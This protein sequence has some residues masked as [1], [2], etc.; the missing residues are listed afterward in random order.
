MYFTWHN[1]KVLLNSTGVA[2]FDAKI[3]LDTNLNPLYLTQ[4]TH[5]Q[6]FNAGAGIGGQFSL[7]YFLT[8][9]DPLKTFM[10]Y[11]NDVISGYFGGLYFRSGYL[12]S[13][14]L[15]CSPNAPVIASADIAFFDQ[16]SGSF[17]KTYDRSTGTKILNFCDAS[18]IDTSNDG[19][20]GSLGKLSGINDIQ[21]SFQSN[22]NPLYLAGDQLPAA[23]NFGKKDLLAS[24]VVDCYSGDLPITGKP[25]GIK[26]NFNHP[27]L[28]GLSESFG[29]S[30]V[31]FKRDLESTV[32]DFVKA[33]LYIRQSFADPLPGITTV[34]N[35]S[36]APGASITINGTN[37]QNTLSV[38]IR[39][40]AASFTV[41]S[42]TQLTVTV[43]NDV[44][45]G[46]VVITT[47][48][49]IVR[50]G[51]FTPTYP[52][53]TVD[54]LQTISG[55]IS[56]LAF[57]SGSNFY[58]VTDVR[59][60]TTSPGLFTGSSGFSVLN[61]SLIAAPIPIDAAWGPVL[62]MATGRNVSGQ[63]TEKFVPI[64]TIYGFYPPSGLSGDSIII[65]GQGFSGVTGILIN[66]LPAISPFTATNTVV[67]N[68]GISFTVPTGN[69]RGLIKI[70]AQSGISTTSINSFGPFASIT[71][72]IPLSG[73]T[74][75]ALYILGHNLFPDIMYSLGNDSFAV[76]F[77]NNATGVFFRT[78]FVNPRFTGL[79]GL[80]PYGAKSGI[81]GIN[82]DSV[83]TYPS[84]TLFTLINEPP[85]IIGVSPKSGMYSGYID[86]TGTN[87]FDVSAV[88]LS[89]L[90]VITT[91]SNPTPL[92]NAAGDTVSFRVPVLTPK[93]TGDIYTVIVE[94]YMGANATGNA[95]FTILDSPIFSGFTG[96]ALLGTSG[97]LGDKILV[98]GKNI[99]PNSQIF[100]PYTGLSGESGQAF[101]DSGYFLSNN[102]QIVFY[103]PPSART[104]LSNIILYNG[105][106]YAS[107]ANFKLINRPTLSGNQYWNAISGEWGTGISISGSFLSNVTGV[108]IGTGI[109]ATFTIIT[110]TGITFTVPENS[111]T[112]YV[113]IYSLAGSSTSTGKL[114]IYTPLPTFS[115]FSPTRGYSGDQ[116]IFSGTRLNTVDTIYF[117]GGNTQVAFDYRYFTRVGSTGINL[118]IPGGITSGQ[119]TIRN[120][121][122]LV[123][124]SAFFEPFLLPS[125]S[126]FTPTF[127]AHT[128]SI[129]ITGSN[130]SGMYVWFISPNSGKYVSGLNQTRV[131]TTGIVCT[132]PREITV[133]PISVSGSG[134]LW[135]S[136]S[137]N[138]IPL[139][140]ISGFGLS[141][142]I[143]SGGQL[144]ISGLN[145]TQVNNIIF[146]TGSGNFFNIISGSFTKDLTNASGGNILDQ[147]TGYT[148]LTAT[149][150][151]ITVDTGKLAIIS[152]YY[153]GISDTSSFLTSA[154]S[155][156][157][158]NIISTNT[159]YLQETTPMPY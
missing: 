107:G 134:R 61:S 112:D 150:N 96:G 97:A 123:T 132:V 5:S 17:T 77:P 106:D 71:G 30:G 122:G 154:I 109:P 124:S 152:A 11:E 84:N 111:E 83:S 94:T 41:N 99:Y 60:S 82:Y 13:Y 47:H 142:G 20:G 101:V 120:P 126:G 55:N 115:G 43:P 125:I 63:S 33:R 87:F 118:P 44:I 157:L 69:V 151:S 22:I 155:D 46:D 129:S 149:L 143:I 58:R 68:T 52:A 119:I 144:R 81:I 95:L 73:R 62:V 140:T 139:P 21:F 27:E 72:I 65:S 135:S 34:S 146:L 75:T 4:E 103:V 93:L 90:G 79:S 29:V 67:G 78:Q 136:S 9:V 128:E 10:T 35:L 66:N 14:S 145:A 45:S 138:F 28:P 56:G 25:A 91:I 137:Q 104:G 76:T 37:L 100:I 102:S 32:G 57:I 51:L 38:Y 98:S 88:K 80:I 159:F 53:I 16:L 54:K 26:V 116:L 130:L 156:K 23:I 158:A 49:G 31:L 133:G 148:L 12:K 131:G 6:F 74:G 86:I 48:G 117:T 64:P 92:A 85:T 121:K 108:Q 89:G 36:A 127:G 24:F 42:N 50:K 7:S 3:S 39:D 105:V 1:P 114:T 15:N 110:D 40:A 59:F 113:S 141:T 8:G 18:L 2:C 153:S 147:T 19:A 70:L